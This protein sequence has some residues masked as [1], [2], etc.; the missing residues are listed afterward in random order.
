MDGGGW[1]MEV[2]DSDGSCLRCPDSLLDGLVEFLG[3]EDE[4]VHGLLV[5]LGV[6]VDP[7]HGGLDGGQHPQLGAQGGDLL[8]HLDTGQ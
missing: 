2:P 6:H 8:T 3:I 1:R 7:H 4:H 5:L